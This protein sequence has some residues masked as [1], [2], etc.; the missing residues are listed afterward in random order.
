LYLTLRLDQAREIDQADTDP[1]LAAAVQSVLDELCRNGLP[2]RAIK[3]GDRAPDFTLADA[4]GVL[5]RL[6][7]HLRNPLVLSFYRGGWCPFC[8]QELLTL[9]E[10]LPEIRALGADLLAISPEDRQAARATREDKGVTF[11]T[12]IDPGLAVARSYGLAF[13]VG[14]VWD[15]EYRALGLDLKARH[16]TREAELPIPATYVIDREGMVRMAF[17]EP[18][19]TQ[20]LDPELVLHALTWYVS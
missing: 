12:L 16:G 20:R 11:T 7:D 19:F 3:E 17:V 9:E 13:P 15:E 14:P 6:A 1:R 18:D 10:Y 2:E 5:H 4:D 8:T